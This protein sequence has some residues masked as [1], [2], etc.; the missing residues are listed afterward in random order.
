[1]NKFNITIA[2]LRN[3]GAKKKRQ[4][5]AARQAEKKKKKAGAG[6]DNV[7]SCSQLLKQ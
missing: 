6:S 2:D 5:I 4:H 7:K 3:T 1:M